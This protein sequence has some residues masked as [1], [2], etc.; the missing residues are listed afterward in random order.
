[1]I[2]KVIKFLNLILIIIAI[3]ISYLMFTNKEVNFK[4]LHNLFNVITNYLN[5]GYKEKSVSSSIK[6]INIENDNYFNYDYQ[7]YAP[8]NGTILDCN[9]NSIIV[10]CE[11][12]YLA[13]FENLI[14]VNVSKF[15]VVYKNDRLANF[16]ETF[17]FYYFLNGEK[18]TYEEII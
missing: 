10:K 2:K 13:I 15:D 4:K 17:T 16:I 14:N 1:M 3:I 9:D 12:G 11:N 6:F 5:L 7:V 8:S 18:Y